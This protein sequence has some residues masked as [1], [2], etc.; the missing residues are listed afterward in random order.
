MF[1]YRPTPFGSARSLCSPLA[2]RRG[3]ANSKELVHDV[4]RERDFID[5]V[6][7]GDGG[8]ERIP[9]WGGKGCGGFQNLGLAVDERPDDGELISFGSDRDGL[10]LDAAIREYDFVDYMNDSVACLH[11]SG[12]HVGLINLHAGGNGDSG[13]P[14]MHGADGAGLEIAGAEAW[15][16]VD[17]VEEDMAKAIGVLKER[18]D[19]T[20]G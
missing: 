2:L 10:A 12:D 11:V 5:A 18:F 1:P 8:A 19:R 20:G 3:G 9:R 6:A 15:A 17:V 7:G 4:A 14:T 16:V 13:E